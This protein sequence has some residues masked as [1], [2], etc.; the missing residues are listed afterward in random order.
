MWEFLQANW[1]KILVVIL[2][3][4][5]AWKYIYTYVK[6]VVKPT[7]QSQPINIVLPKEGC[8]ITV[9]PLDK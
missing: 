2:A 3:V 5:S 9:K 8:I 1:H 7:N 6:P 4:A